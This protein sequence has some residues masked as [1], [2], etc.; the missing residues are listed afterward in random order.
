MYILRNITLTE[1]KMHVCYIHMSICVMLVDEMRK[2]LTCATHYITQEP[3]LVK[4]LSTMSFAL[5][6]EL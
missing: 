3:D 5:H 1:L 2:V 4:I 6:T